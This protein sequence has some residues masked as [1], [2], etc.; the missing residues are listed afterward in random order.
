M[1]E[2][3]AMWQKPRVPCEGQAA[4]SPALAKNWVNYRKQE[5]QPATDSIHKW[6]NKNTKR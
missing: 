6:I 2:A 3:A 4:H 1:P 5:S